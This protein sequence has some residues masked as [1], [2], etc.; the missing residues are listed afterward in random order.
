MDKYMG[1]G[2]FPKYGNHDVKIKLQWG[3]YKGEVITSLGGNSIGASVIQTIASMLEDGD[4][5]FKRTAVNEK[6]I[7]FE[8]DD[9]KQYGYPKHFNLYDG[10]DV[11]KI[12]A[13]DGECVTGIEIIDFQEEKHD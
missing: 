4:M 13:R 5:S 10:E 11:L 6:H 9:G 3:T 12:D 2:L 8:K 7:E 1:E